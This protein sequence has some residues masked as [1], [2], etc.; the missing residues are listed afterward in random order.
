MQRDGDGNAVRRGGNADFIVGRGHLDGQADDLPRRGQPLHHHRQRE[1]QQLRGLQRRNVE[2]RA[3]RGD[4]RIREYAQQTGKP[5]VEG[6]E[7][8]AGLQHR[9]DRQHILDHLGRTDTGQR[10]LMVAVGHRRGDLEDRIRR[11]VLKLADGYLEIG[12]SSR[13]PAPGPARLRIPAP[14][15]ARPRGSAIARP[16]ATTR[17]GSDPAAPKHCLRPEMVRAGGT[18]GGPDRRCAAA[19]PRR[20]R[21]RSCAIV[22]ARRWQPWCLRPVRWR[23]RTP[24]SAAPAPAAEAARD[25]LSAARSMSGSCARYGCVL[26]SDGNRRP[27]VII[28]APALRSRLGTT[29]KAPSR[30]RPQPAAL[31]LP[32]LTKN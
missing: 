30:A 23:V 22:R 6:I 7:C 29:Q 4:L 32:A 31:R 5:A 15:R 17:G 16:A 27:P 9:A 8:F 18:A 3:Y 12:R 10:A 26:R 21:A 28:K 13:F 24:A 1:R 11:R 2:A 25:S 20:F 14:D 19:P